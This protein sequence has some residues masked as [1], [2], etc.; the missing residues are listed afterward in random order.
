[1]TNYSIRTAQEKLERIYNLNESK[2]ARSLKFPAGFKQFLNNFFAFLS[3]SEEPR[4]RVHRDRSGQE[5]YYAYDPVTSSSFSSTEET[6]LRRWL[7]E[8]YYR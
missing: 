5:V 7:E 6:E 4:V 3:A 8:R 2:S 1:M